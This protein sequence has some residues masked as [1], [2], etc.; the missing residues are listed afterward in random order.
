MLPETFFISEKNKTDSQ[1]NQKCLELCPTN[2]L[3]V[4]SYLLLFAYIPANNIE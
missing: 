2:C 4:Y 3:K 1:E